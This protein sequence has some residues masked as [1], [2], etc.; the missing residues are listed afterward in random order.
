[1][2]QL[3]CNLLGHPHVLHRSDVRNLWHDDGGCCW[4]LGS[5]QLSA[6]LS[7]SNTK[8]LYHWGWDDSLPDAV[9]RIVLPNCCLKAALVR[10]HPISLLHQS[11][12]CLLQLGESCG[13]I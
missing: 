12:A 1:M 10:L 3:I 7:A 11:N 6:D 9:R 2:L 5:S 8:L 4:L 13:W